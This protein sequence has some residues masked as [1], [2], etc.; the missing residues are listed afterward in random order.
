M[1]V[2]LDTLQRA[3]QFVDGLS[4][5]DEPDMAA[6][7]LLPGLAD[8]IGCDIATYQK[9]SAEPCVGDY[10]EYPVGSLDPAALEVF[11]AHLAEHPLVVRY[12][13][14]GIGAG[15][16]ARISD[17]VS[18][19]AFRRLGIYSEYFRHV[20]TDDQIAFV[21]PGPRDGER[22]GITL[23]RAGREF[24]QEDSAVLSSI[25]AP[26]SSA[27]RRSGTR[28]RARATA[29]AGAGGLTGLS[30]RET[31]VLELAAAGRT[32]LAIARAI[33]VSPRTVAKHLEHIYRKL[34]VSG[35]AAAVYRTAGAPDPG[36][37][38]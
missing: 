17:V 9:I 28:Y 27:L 14:A 5:L 11:R 37:A 22:V 33:D 6:E 18:R 25:M 32:N 26:V 20:P 21:V 34:G 7:F 16:P 12:R 10:T 36:Q 30:G 29:A 2:S 15:G 13:A 31:Q 24:G 1:H 23:S 3:T 38:A 4:D 19:Q 8:L 35:R